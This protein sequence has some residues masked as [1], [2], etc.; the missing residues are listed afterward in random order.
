MWYRARGRRHCAGCVLV[1]MRCQP[2][3]TQQLALLLLTCPP[4]S[5]TD[6]ERLSVLVTD[7][8][9]MEEKQEEVLKVGTG[10]VRGFLVAASLTGRGFTSMSAR[11]TSI[12]SRVY[13]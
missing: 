5:P 4:C 13:F 11:T 9:P 10:P 6:L 2:A 7:A 1:P 8:R 12:C 3:A